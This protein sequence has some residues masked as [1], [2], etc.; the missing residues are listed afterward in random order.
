MRCRFN[1]TRKEA[2][3]TIN[4]DLGSIVHKE[5]DIEGDVRNRISVG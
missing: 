5:G 4:I 3:G 1:N 2:N